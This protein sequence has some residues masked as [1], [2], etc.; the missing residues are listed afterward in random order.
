M[1]PVL[2]EC[3]WIASRHRKWQRV[4]VN[5]KASYPDQGNYQ[6]PFRLVDDAEQVPGLEAAAVLAQGGILVV[7]IET[8]YSVTWEKER[9]GL[10][11][12]IHKTEGVAGPPS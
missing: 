2:R 12:L 1:K 7:G 11:E 5:P 6:G 9:Q 8:D 3:G 4:K 10:G